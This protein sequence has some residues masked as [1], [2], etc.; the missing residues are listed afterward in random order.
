MPLIHFQEKWGSKAL[1]GDPGLTSAVINYDVTSYPKL[2]LTYAPSSPIYA[3]IQPFISIFTVPGKFIGRALSV[4]ESMDSSGQVSKKVTAAGLADVLHDSIQPWAEFHNT[5]PRDFLQALINNHNTQV[6]DY[7]KISLGTVTVTNSTDNVYRYTDDAVDT[8]QTIQDKLVS[9]LGGEIEVVLNNGQLVLNYVPKVGKQGQQIIALKRNLLA[10]TETI[11]LSAI[12]TVLKPLGATLDQGTDAQSN[13]R[14]TIKDVNGGS[15]YLR[16]EGLISQFG[17]QV[18]AQTWDDV[19]TASVLLTRGKD[20]LANQN[21]INNAVQLTAVDLS[22]IGKRAD[23]FVNGNEYRVV[24]PIM[25]FDRY[26][27][28]VAQSLD[29]LNPANSTLT[30]GNPQQTLEQY[31]LNIQRDIDNGKRLTQEL[32]VTQQRLKKL[33]D[34]SASSQSKINELTETAK[35]LQEEIE[36]LKPSGGGG[37]TYSGN[38][39][40]V[41]EWQ[42]SID[43]SKVVNAG[44]ALAIIRVQHG[45]AHEDLTYKVNIP[46]AINAGANYAVYA[47]FAATSTSDAAVEANDFYN[48]AKAVIGAGRQPRFWAIDVE[49]VE[50]G[51]NVGAMRAGVEAYMDKLNALGV[52]DSQIVLYIANHLYSQFN[53]NVGRAGAIWIPSYGANDGT[54]GGSTKPTHP[55]DLW[56]YTSTGSVPGI[57]GNVD[58][59][60]DPSDRFK[61]QFL[62]K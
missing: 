43:W 7:K 32:Q 5:T 58:L 8:Y 2:E 16:D 61:Q 31:R 28:V 19:T 51:G 54:V 60:T 29:L 50:M 53:L 17:V 57:S 48:R 49:T 14:L 9:R 37:G 35:Q 52:P 27:R 41:S 62:S 44:L 25:G 33:A 1:N 39:I 3:R 4:E 11:D 24:N 56:Q 22:L 34:E 15:P 23:S 30:M 42:K 6:E 38:I 45:S 47:Y 36:K 12:A 13:P 59:S 46:A 10:L 55:Y 40:D 26:M 21:L 18:K 20:Y